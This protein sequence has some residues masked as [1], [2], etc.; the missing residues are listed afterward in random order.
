M[1]T[2][3]DEAKRTGYR[4]MYLDTL[5]TGERAIRLYEKAGFKVTEQYNENDA[6]DIFMVLDTG[7]LMSL[8]RILCWNGWGIQDISEREIR[9]WIMAAAKDVRTFFCP[10]RPGAGPLVLSMTNGSMKRQWTTRRQPSLP[11]GQILKRQ[12]QNTSQYRNVWTGSIFSTRF[13]LNSCRR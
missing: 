5:S 8:H 10:G 11:G 13:P 3:I 2:A 1:D 6:A 9:F 7:I 12:M 4:E